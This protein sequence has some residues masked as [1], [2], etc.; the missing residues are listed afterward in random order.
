MARNLGLLM[1]AHKHSQTAL[2]KLAGVDQTLIGKIR[3]GQHSTGIDKLER[4]AA[5][6]G[7]QA[8]HLLLPNLPEELIG[9]GEIE[10]LYRDFCNSETSG[11][12]LISQIAEREAEHSLTNTK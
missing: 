10:K 7:L 5:V 3:R 1:D 8:W 11:R 9:G 12:N 6:Y 4:I 2:G